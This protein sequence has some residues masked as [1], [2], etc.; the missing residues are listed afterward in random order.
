M[1]EQYSFLNNTLTVGAP[2]EAPIANHL[3]I[4]LSLDEEEGE[5]YNG[6]SNYKTTEVYL[7]YD[8]ST[9]EGQAEFFKDAIKFTCLKVLSKSCDYTFNYYQVDSKVALLQPSIDKIKDTEVYDSFMMGTY[10]VNFYYIDASGAKRIC[11]LTLTPELKA[12][13]GACDEINKAIKSS[14]RGG[15]RAEERKD[16][17]AQMMVVFEKICILLDENIAVNEVTSTQTSSEIQS[18]K[19]KV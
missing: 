14:Y 11:E 12:A 9:L 10:S 18:K 6:E 19:H 7:N 3:Q 8:A 13:F 17:I 5:G 4:N 1:L 2:L 16:K 15:Y